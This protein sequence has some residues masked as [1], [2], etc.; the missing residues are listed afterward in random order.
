VVAVAWQNRYEPHRNVLSLYDWQR[1]PDGELRLCLECFGG[2]DLFEAWIQQQQH[3][4]AYMTYRP[5]YA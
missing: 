1:S 2:V 3:G 4:S 5:S